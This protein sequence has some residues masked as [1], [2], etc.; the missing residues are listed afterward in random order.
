MQQHKPNAAY[1]AG[2]SVRRRSGPKWKNAAVSKQGSPSDGS[3]GEVHFSYAAP[4]D[5]WFRRVAIHVIEHITG[6]PRLKA[7]YEDY[8]AAPNRF[9]SFWDAAIDYLDL[10]I[11][12][13]QTA[14]E[15][16]PAAGPLVLVANHPFGVV[17]GLVAGH[18]VHKVRQD[19]KIIANAVLLRAPEIDPFVLPI[20][21]EETPEALKTN[22]ETRKLARQHLNGGGCLIILPAGGVATAPSPFE[23]NALEADWKNF[24]GRLVIQTRA[25]VVPLYFEGQNSRAFHVASHISQTLRLSL[26]FREACKQIGTRIKVHVGAPLAPDDLSEFESAT[27]LTDHLR[28]KTLSLNTHHDVN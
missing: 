12:A 6:Q 15:M 18:L 13:D 5:G 7:M 8:I 2:P 21:F 11:D 17:D 14:I 23:R 3:G 24:T 20:D 27:H 4:G 16:I 22:I 28:T 1:T 25:S 26:L 9:S 10:D 19:F